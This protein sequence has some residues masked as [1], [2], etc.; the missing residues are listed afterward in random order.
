[1]LTGLPPFY[2]QNINETYRKVLQE[3]LTFPGSNRVARDLLT[4][5]LHL[6]HRVVLVPTLPQESSRTTSLPILTGTN[7][8]SKSMEAHTINA[9]GIKGNITTF[10]KAN[11]WIIANNDANAT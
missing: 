8:F 2:D 10:L 9:A 7:C 4:Q 6:G 5:V 3:P 11:D 1:M